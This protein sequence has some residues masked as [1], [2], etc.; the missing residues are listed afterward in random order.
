VAWL[1]GLE[2]SF[3]EGKNQPNSFGLIDP[4]SSAAIEGSGTACG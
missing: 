3:A 1:T 2:G 4:I